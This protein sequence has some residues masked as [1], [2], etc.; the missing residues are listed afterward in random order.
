MKALLRKIR[1]TLGKLIL[2]K[3]IPG[4]PLPTNP[5]IIVLQQDGKIGDYIIS[6]FIFRELKKHNPLAQV[7]VI[8]SPKNENLFK[9]N[10][11]IDH[12][13][14]LDKKSTMCLYKDGGKTSKRKL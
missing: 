6:S 5:K 3:K 10:H 8:C 2:D 12:F 4:K 7:D 11:F 1:L 9:T 14:V 13:F